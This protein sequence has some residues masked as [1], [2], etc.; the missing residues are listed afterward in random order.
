V[1]QDGRFVPR[2]AAW[3]S[4]LRIQQLLR[5]PLWLANIF[6]LLSASTLDKKNFVKIFGRAKEILSVQ[7]VR[8]VMTSFPFGGPV[9]RCFTSITNIF[10]LF[11]R[12]QGESNDSS[13]FFRLCMS[14]HHLDYLIA[15][16]VW[17]Q[18]F[19]SFYF[20]SFLLALT[21]QPKRPFPRGTFVFYTMCIRG[22]S[23]G[24][25]ITFRLYLSWGTIPDK[26][27]SL[28]FFARQVFKL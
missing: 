27:I 13:S 7:C 3:R 26:S 12:I 10:L 17:S 6:Y 4:L 23:F 28:P 11:L 21:I 22:A 9:T 8:T 5:F 19:A 1:R 18:V 24:I 15:R 2:Y 20:F 14:S 16:E 25:L